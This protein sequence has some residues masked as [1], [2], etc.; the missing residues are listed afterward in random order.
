[1]K[2]D[3]KGDG[4]FLLAKMSLFEVL[5]CLS[6]VGRCP[7]SPEK[8][9][10]KVSTSKGWMRTFSS[11]GSSRLWAQAAAQQRRKR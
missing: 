5:F 9:N 10:I 11:S 4:N 1:M 8:G 3:S 6:G 7:N 2:G